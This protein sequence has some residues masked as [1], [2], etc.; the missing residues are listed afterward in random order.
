MSGVYLKL[1][2]WEAAKCLPAAT[3]FL[4]WCLPKTISFQCIYGFGKVQKRITSIHEESVTEQNCCIAP[5][6]CACLS[7]SE[8]VTKWNVMIYHD[9]R[10]VLSWNVT[11]YHHMSWNVT[12][13]HHMSWNVTM[14]NWKT[15]HD[16]WWHKPKGNFDDIWWFFMTFLKFLKSCN[17]YYS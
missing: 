10:H 15:F 9:K 8:G 6:C 16:I 7:E 5:G 2:C 14:L 11:K 1:F 13:Y 4:H 3:Q 12:N 17:H